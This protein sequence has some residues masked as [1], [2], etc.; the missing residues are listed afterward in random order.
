MCYK[1][2]GPR[3]TPQADEKSARAYDDVNSYRAAHPKA[4]FNRDASTWSVDGIFTRKALRHMRYISDAESSAGGRRRLAQGG[5][6]LKR[7]ILDARAVG[8]MDPEELAR[9][10]HS[11]RDVYSRWQDA[12]K[13]DKAA[14]FEENQHRRARY[15]ARKTQPQPMGA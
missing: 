4:R 6:E 2:P 8:D 10:E 15:A 11:L 3:C 12:S 14:K 1:L 13:R 5:T 9:L 7:M